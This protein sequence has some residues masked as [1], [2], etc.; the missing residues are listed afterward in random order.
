MIDGDLGEWRDVRP[1]IV[2]AADAPQAAVDLRD[3]RAQ[4]D[5]A[6][7]YLAV[8]WERPANPQALRGL[9]SILLDGDGNPST[10]SRIHDMDGVDLIVE[11]SRQD[12]PRADGY[13]TGVALRPVTTEGAGELIPGA[14]LG[15]VIAPTYSAPSFELRLR[16][17]DSLAGVPPLF[18]DEAIGVQLVLEDGEGVR[19]RTDVG[20][21]ELSTRASPRHGVAASIEAVRKR[22]GLLRVVA[23]N[24]AGMN[25][26]DHGNELGRV[27]AA[28]APD[29]VLFDEA[30]RGVTVEEVRT[31]LAS[32][33]G[34]RLWNVHIAEGGG[35][36]KTVVAS[37][38][39]IRAAEGMQAVAYP[40]GALDELV[41]TAGLDTVRAR[42]EGRAGL[43]TTGA[44]VDVGGREILFVPFDLQSAGYDGSWED[45]LRVLQA[46]VLRD[47]IRETAGAFGE[48]AMVVLGGD[49]NLVGSETPM[50]VLES[51]GRT[52]ADIFRLTD[53]T[54]ATWRNPEQ[55]LFTPGWLDF[56]VYGG[57]GLDFVGGFAFEP[58][59][60]DEAA[61]RELGVLDTDGRSVSDHLPVVGDFRVR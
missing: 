50:R 56:L 14:H 41:R 46:T 10:G 22:E 38:L 20:R 26:R 13:G 44:W 15:L 49:A 25:G 59:E 53:R 51:D 29:V 3:V 45:R 18:Q 4:D 40:D 23:W 57:A 7:L 32:V 48:D 19:D 27:L 16:R 1:I 2:D 11:L 55:G 9:V 52:R 37:R 47:R 31:L 17:G 42:I 12:R 58:A 54:R 61:R 34:G 24:I 5:P 33:A 30:W 6:F 28:V 39:P 21:Y 60:L 43:A 35:R 8:D 36:Q